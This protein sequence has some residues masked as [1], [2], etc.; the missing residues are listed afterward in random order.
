MEDRKIGR[1]DIRVKQWE[2]LESFST[3]TLHDAGKLWPDRFLCV[4]Q[5]YSNLLLQVVF[6]FTLK[7]FFIATIYRFL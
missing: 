1:I 7:A 3:R 4:S 2:N 5:R 6:S